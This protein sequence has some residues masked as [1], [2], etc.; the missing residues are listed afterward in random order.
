MT[1]L[2]YPVPPAARRI[3]PHKCRN[4]C[5]LDRTGPH[6]PR[7]LLGRAGQPRE[8]DRA[9][10]Q[11][12]Q[13]RLHRRRQNQSGM[14]TA[15]STPPPP[16]SIGTC[17]TVRTRSPSSGRATDPNA[18]KT[19]T[20]RELHEQVC[21]FAN[22]LKSLGAQ[23]G[24]RITIYL[25]MVIEAAVAM[26]ACARIGAIH[27]IVFGGF[28]PDS[29]ANRIQDCDSTILITA[30]EGR[31]G[32]RKVRAQDQCR[33]RAEDVPEHPSTSS[34]S[35]SPA[36]TV[37]MQDGRDHD[38]EALV[39][40][41]S[42]ECPPEPMEAEAPL[43]I[44]YTSGS[45]GKPKGVL[46]TTGG[47]MVWAAMTPSTRVRLPRG[48]SLL[49]HRRCRLGHRAHLY[50]LRPARQRRDHADVRG[51]P[52]LPRQL[53]LLAGDRQA[54]GQHLLH[55]ADRHPLAD[56]RRRGP[57]EDPPAGRACGCSAASAS[58]SIPRPG[59]GITGSWARGA[60]RSSTPGGRP[61][62]AAS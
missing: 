23:K 17:T 12:P 30:D 1:D 54:P 62:P 59:R 13:R 43:F 37:P 50:R 5:R 33:C 55:R 58:R 19:I 57:G 21:R 25:P 39:A 16:A 15:S 44:L 2:L 49:V 27:S 26:L 56:A 22:A 10:A 52:D 35:P 11:D 6:R 31:R 36:A 8:L 34:S 42:P 51:H 24:D 18:H 3:L 46:H 60:A 20:Y 45:T 40:A 32:G 38:Y 9:A 4:V 41:A 48:R 47:Y 7:W 53:P 29:L 28:S 61:R 14:R